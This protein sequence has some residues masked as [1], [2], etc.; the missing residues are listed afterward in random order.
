VRDGRTQRGSVIRL[1]LLIAFGLVLVLR[2]AAGL[3][4]PAN[5]GM[6]DRPCPPEDTGLAHSAGLV[7]RVMAGDRPYLDDWLGLCTFD[8]DNR[9]RIAGGVQT[10]AVFLGDS[11]TAAWW[12]RDP[13]LFSPPVAN[14]GISGQT[15]AQML[16]RFSA[17]VI[18]LRP[19][20]V[21]ILAGTNDVLGM[22]GPSSPAVYQGNLR[23]LVD[24]AQANGIAVVL[25]S[26]PPIEQP[27]SEQVRQL[28][29]WLRQF[30][31][32]RGIEFVDYYQLLAAPDGTLQP[33]FT[34]DG[35]HLTEAAYA[36]MGPQARAALARARVPSAR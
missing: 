12:V 14:R 28:N 6:V 32:S 33:R 36:L 16:A 1:S 29:L 15:T 26:L 35:I 23:A 10:D 31:A 18:P 30:A 24:L 22:G 20:A 5:P 4:A 8:A 9:A 34:D 3:L 21:H 17:D 13:A 19:R 7:V 27:H 25:G 11:L 2:L